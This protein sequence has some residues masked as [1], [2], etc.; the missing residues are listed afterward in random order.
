MGPSSVVDATCLLFTLSVD[1]RPNPPSVPFLS[2]RFTLYSSPFACSYVFACA[3]P[4]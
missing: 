2:L 3:A 4:G 1:Y